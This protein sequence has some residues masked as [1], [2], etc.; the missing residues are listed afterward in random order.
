[1]P[2]V[3]QLKIGQEEAVKRCV[4]SVAVILLICP[5]ARLETF[6]ASLPTGQ[7]YVYVLDEYPASSV[8]LPSRLASQR[9]EDGH[10]IGFLHWTCAGL[11]GARRRHK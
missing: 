10:L 7:I 3:F 4:N 9:A 6:D 11:E 2:A 5:R 1:M 8:S